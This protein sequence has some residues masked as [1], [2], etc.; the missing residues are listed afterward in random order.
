MRYDSAFFDEAVN[1]RG[2]ACEKWDA[3]MEREGREL[4]PM[5]VA[6]MDFRCPQEVQDALVSRARHPIYG[7]TEQT[8]EA[9]RA[10]LDFMARR[11]RLVIGEEEQAMLPCVVTGLRAAVLAFTDPGDSIIVQP[12]VYGPFY[13]AI[14]DNGRVAAECPLLHGEGGRYTMDLEAVEAACQNGSKMMFLCNPHN[15]VG[16]AWTRTELEA[17]LAVLNRYGVLLI[18]DEIHEDFVFE[19]GA[20]TPVLNLETGRHARVISMTS[21]SKTFNL[22]GLQ[23]AAAFCRNR[24]LLDGLQAAMRNAGVVMGNIFGMIATEAAFRH[25]D[26]WLDA[27]LPYIR[28]GE[29][30]FRRELSRRLPPAVLT[31]LEATYLGWIDLRAYGLSTEALMRRCNGAGVTFTPGTFFGQEAGEGFLRINYACPHSRIIDA[32]ARLETAVKQ[33]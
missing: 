20:F 11:H 27:M 1:R 30:L 26:E 8:R 9:T 3:L 29:S 28:E 4:N 22:A 18:S 33:E 13:A 7:Y 25:G 17:L 2:T 6:D 12:P 15:P 32:A 19:R 14:R 24:E 31:P 21:A 16:R 10:M 5:W 23:Q